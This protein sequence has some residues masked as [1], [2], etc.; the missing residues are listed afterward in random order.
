M[1]FGCFVDCIGWYYD[2]DCK[3]GEY[4]ADIGAMNAEADVCINVLFRASSE[5]NVEDIDRRLL[6]MEENW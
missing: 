4:V 3:T 2:V 1:E 6:Y 5:T